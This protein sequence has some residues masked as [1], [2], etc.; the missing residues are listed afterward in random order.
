MP[1]SAFLGDSFISMANLIC[2]L[3]MPRRFSMAYRSATY[4]LARLYSLAELHLVHTVVDH[5]L[6]ILH[7]N[8][9]IPQAGQ[10]RECEI[11]VSDGRLEWAFYCGTLCVNVNPLVVERSVSEQIDALLRELYI[12]RHAEVLAEICGKFMIAVD[13]NFAHSCIF[14]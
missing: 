1:V 12:V 10:H 2:T 13:D 4:V 9:L 8:N 14:K 3:A 11:A 7:L 6:K 5:H